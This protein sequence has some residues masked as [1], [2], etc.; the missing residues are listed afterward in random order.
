MK[1]HS[2]KKVGRPRHNLTYTDSYEVTHHTPLIVPFERNPRFTDRE[3]E[4]TKA[5]AAVGFAANILQFVDSVCHVLNVGRQLRRHGMTDFNWDLERSTKFLEHQ[6]ARIRSQQGA[7][8][9][10]DEADQVQI[11]GCLRLCMLI[12][13]SR[14]WISL[15]KNVLLS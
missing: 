11:I 3:S 1:T 9:G 12:E 5:L 15:Q 13:A 14:P 10:L 2:T 7:V 6:V 4:L 8:T